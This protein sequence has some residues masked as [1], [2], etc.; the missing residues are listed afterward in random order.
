MLGNAPAFKVV[1]FIAVILHVGGITD[2][3]LSFSSSFVFSL[4]LKIPAGEGGENE[5]G[6]SRCERCGRWREFPAL[7]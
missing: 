4:F 1:K 6:V 3:N 7:P 2:R 5:G